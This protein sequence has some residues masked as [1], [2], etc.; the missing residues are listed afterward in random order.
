MPL[1]KDYIR[2]FSLLPHKLLISVYLILLIGLGIMYS[3]STPSKP[4]FYK[5]LIH[6]II[7]STAMFIL[8]FTR[9]RTIFNC[10]YLFYGFTLLILIAVSLMGH[11][12]MGATRWLD[13]G[14]IKIQ[15][16][17]L[18][19]IGVIMALAR[20]FHTLQDHKISYSHSLLIPLIIAAAPILIVLKQPDL[21]TAMTILIV[22]AII[23]FLAGV[24]IWKFILSAV[25]F[26]AA[27][28]IIWH[29]LYDYQKKRILTF[30][31]PEH[32]P[33]GAG[34][35]IMQSKI[36]IGSGGLFGKGVSESSQAKLH[37]LPEYQTDFVFSLFA[38]E[39][40]FL[41]STALIFLFLIVILSGIKIAN[42]CSS[43]FGK[44]LAFGLI[45]VMSIHVFINIGMVSGILP[46]VGIPLPLISY[47]G[48]SLSTS[49]ISIGMIMSV[50][51]N[52]RIS[53]Q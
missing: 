29:N 17:E 37:F 30:L 36:A 46:V 9:L 19:K 42:N 43:T 18:V 12:A 20:Y 50:K 34:Y 21:G 2:K 11:T 32:D 13:L 28:P 39:Y 52:E 41:A 45:S 15:P 53:L 6:A 51:I 7:A 44:L 31:N 24:Q 16:S 48:S 40:G 8:A 22:T 1:L 23:L 25:M 26:L 5:Q 35:N 10:A 27:M 3:I 14:F 38:E 33:L 47:G 49:L 4:L